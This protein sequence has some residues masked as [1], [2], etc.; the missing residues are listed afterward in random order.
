MTEFVNIID[1]DVVVIFVDIVK[2]LTIEGG[3]F[4]MSGEK[5][6]GFIFFVFLVINENDFVI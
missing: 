5:L 6:L 1:I 3:Y 4:H 2:I